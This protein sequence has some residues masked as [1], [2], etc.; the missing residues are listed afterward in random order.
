LPRQQSARERPPFGVSKKGHAS[1]ERATV[2]LTGINTKVGRGI[3]CKMREGEK[4][5]GGGVSPLLA[6]LK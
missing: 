1:G 2:G 3:L 4:V 5:R 6:D